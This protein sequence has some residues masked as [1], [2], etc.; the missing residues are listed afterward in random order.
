MA[1]TVGVSQLEA[2]FHERAIDLRALLRLRIDLE[3]ILEVV[4]ERGAVVAG[5]VD[6]LLKSFGFGKGF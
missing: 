3:E 4:D 2:G 6:G 1:S 5:T